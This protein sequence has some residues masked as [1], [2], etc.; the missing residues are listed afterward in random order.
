MSKS[1]FIS[2]PHNEVRVL[3]DYLLENGQSLTSHSFLSFEAVDFSI[4]KMF[5][6]VF[7]SSPRS[8]QFF[9]ER[10]SLKEGVLIACT[11]HRTAESISDFGYPV[12]FIANES[13]N[14]SKAAEEFKDWCN[15]KRI[16]FPV[17]NISL[18]SIFP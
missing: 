7:F 4:E 3:N 16:L 9:L 2:K 1:I 15:G 13:S 6:V 11:G 14:I 5:D 8:A 17:S 10:S 12:H 18:R